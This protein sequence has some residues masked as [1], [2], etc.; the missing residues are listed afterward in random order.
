[1]SKRSFTVDVSGREHLEVWRPIPGY[2]GYDASNLGRIR[3]RKGRVPLILKQR[4]HYGRGYPVVELCQNNKSRESM[5]HRQVLLAF[6]G[7]PPEGFEACHN[8]GIRTDNRLENLRWDTHS[9]NSF[10]QV[11]HGTH[12]HVRK[13]HCR[14]GHPYDEANTYMHPNGGR[15]CRV[16][17]RDSGKTFYRNHKE[18]WVLTPEQ[19]ARRNERRRKHSKLG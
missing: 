17:K 4:L 11:A 14:N 8:N 5:V 19:S 6:H 7:E 13:T 16:C 18:K 3:S 10:D 1:M 2:D 15:I 9:G 12:H